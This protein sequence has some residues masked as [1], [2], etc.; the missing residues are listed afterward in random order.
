MCGI[1]GIITAARTTS[2]E[3]AAVRAT[4][5]SLTHRGPDGSGEFQDQ[6]VMLAMRRLSIIDLT[7]G[8]Q[9][10]YNEDRTLVLICNGEI[11]NFVELRERSGKSGPSI[12]HQQRLRNHP[13]SLRRTR[14]RLRATPARHVCVCAL[15]YEKQ[16]TATRARSHG[17]EADLLC[18]RPTIASSLLPK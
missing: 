5:S 4:N 9:P 16:T 17:R 11:Y 3:I 1:A 8:W 15:R 13:A 10:L 6:H 2:D 18:T 7:T 14:P 12:Q